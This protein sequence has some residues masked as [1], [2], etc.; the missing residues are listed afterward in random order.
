MTDKIIDK[1]C[2]KSY[3]SDHAAVH[4]ILHLA[5]PPLPSEEV[6]YRKTKDIDHDAFAMD[7]QHSSLPNSPADSLVGLVSQYNLVLA[8]LLDKHA[9]QK[10]RIIT[11][12][13]QAPWHNGNIITAKKVSRR[14]ER[15]WRRTRLVSDRCQ[16][17]AKRQ[18]LHNLITKSKSDYYCEKIACC[19]DQK[20]LFR[21][22]EELLPR[23]K[24]KLPSHENKT[25]LAQNFNSFFSEKIRTVREA[26]DRTNTGDLSILP[27]DAD[28]HAMESFQ[29]ASEEEVAKVIR[30]APSKSCPA[31]P[32]P[33]WLLKRH[34]PILVP[35]ITKIVNMSL[36]QGDFPASM[37]K[38]Q[39]VPLLKKPSLDIEQLKN[40]R[41]VSNLT[42]LS[43][44]IEKIVAV[45][46]N[47]HLSTHQLHEPFQS[48]YRECH[49]TE[50]ALLCVEMTYSEHWIKG[51]L[52]TLY[53]LTFRRPLI[54]LTIVYCWRD[55]SMKSV[56]KV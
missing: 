55:F 14:A 36:D 21:V 19:Q 51:K 42:F 53:S 44:I 4:C 10:T 34:L 11:I 20:G 18:V 33:T 30:S 56:S 7:L 26:L 15:R 16:F 52:C 38:A 9:P 31:D 23:A 27:S 50:T 22:I 32:I 43:K 1:T 2:A 35:T 46:I 37:K 12:R 25:E 45:R 47:N 13:P 54:P 40:D 6:C 3:L 17:Q 41:P 5:K 24:P 39:V 48:A 28:I 8:E 49:G 29:T